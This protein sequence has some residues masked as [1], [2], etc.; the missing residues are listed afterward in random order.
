MKRELF[1]NVKVLPYKSGEAINRSGFL[2]AIVAATAAADGDVTV[3][4]SH[5]STANG[6][7]EAVSEEKLFVNTAN[8]AKGLKTKDTANF[9]IDL[10]GCKQ[11]IKI[12]LSGSAVSGSA[13]YAVVLGDK[14]T[15]PV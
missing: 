7:F 9:D 3:A 12:E 13:G 2:S 8:T 14:N 10:V 15:Q 6:T 5:C 4:V 11:F 1:Q